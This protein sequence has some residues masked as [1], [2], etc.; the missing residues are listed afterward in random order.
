MVLEGD[1]DSGRDVDGGMSSG[2]MASTL[3]GGLPFPEVV[4]HIVAAAGI[5]FGAGL[6]GIVRVERIEVGVLEFPD[7]VHVVVVPVPRFGDADA[8]GAEK[9]AEFVRRGRAI[10]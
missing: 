3:A 6:E 8:P 5:G 7:I 2:E 9:G 10:T 1:G 4:I